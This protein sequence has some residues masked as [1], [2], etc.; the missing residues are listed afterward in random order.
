M[1]KNNIRDIFHH[2]SDFV[3]IRICDFKENFVYRFTLVVRDADK[4]SA[5]SGLLTEERGRW[6]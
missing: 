6:T 2:I 1:R 3:K 5:K 4:E